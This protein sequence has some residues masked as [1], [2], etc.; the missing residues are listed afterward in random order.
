MIVPEVCRL[1]SIRIF[2]SEAAK[3]TATGKFVGG[4]DVRLIMDRVLQRAA[5]GP[6]FDA[7]ERDAR[8]GMPG[9]RACF[10]AHLVM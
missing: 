7:N 6:W 4:G 8:K 9:W 3:Q 2:T 1:P 10:D 5:Q